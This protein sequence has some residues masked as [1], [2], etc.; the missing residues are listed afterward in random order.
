MITLKFLHTQ[1]TNADGDPAALEF[2]KQLVA[3]T[4]ACKWQI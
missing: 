3:E 1:I 2:P 4:V